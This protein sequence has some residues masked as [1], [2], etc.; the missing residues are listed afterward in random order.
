MA[1]VGEQIKSLLRDAPPRAD[2]ILCT[3]F[4][5]AP[6]LDALLSNL[7]KG[8]ELQVFT[9]WH[10]WEVAAGVSDLEVFDLCNDR[11]GSQLYLVDNLHAKAYVAG[12]RALVGSANLTAT[13]LGWSERP[14][15]EI[16][17]EVPST[18][19]ELSALILMLKQNCRKATSREKEIV[20]EEATRLSIPA[21]PE[22]PVK[23][24]LSSPWFPRCAAPEQLYAIYAGQNNV[25]F[26][27]STVSDAKD[28]LKDLLIP[29]GLKQRE[30]RKVI[31]ERL[32]SLSTFN[33]IAE[34]ARGQ[35]NDQSGKEFVRSLRTELDD[36]GAKMLW[37]IVRTWFDHFFD[38]FEV[39]VND[40]V[41]RG[42]S[43]PDG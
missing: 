36:R 38:E 10:A 16:L 8:A 13:A 24:V 34:K 20:F 21:S 22:S 9:R 25:S 31:K 11:P 7:G 14:N 39:A 43:R 40:H 23:R 2:V 12:E 15:I 3:P 37:A 29:E 27:D 5:K 42:R 41:L 35:I 26:L 17:I 32:L 28:D 19:R 6:V 18:V 4:M 30:F 1:I 33:E